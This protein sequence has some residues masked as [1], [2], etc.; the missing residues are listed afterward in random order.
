MKNNTEHLYTDLE[1]VALPMKKKKLTKTKKNINYEQKSS[2]RK[3]NRF[4]YS[5]N[6]SKKGTNEM[7]IVIHIW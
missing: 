2:L 5:T 1:Y 3:A 7:F 6:C 4:L